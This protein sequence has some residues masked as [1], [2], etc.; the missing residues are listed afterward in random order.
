MMPDLVEEIPEALLLQE[1]GSG[2]R[3]GVE[4]TQTAEVA[5]RVTKCGENTIGGRS[6][7]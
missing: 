3:H 5:V 2:T 4:S 1:G 6:K 7:C